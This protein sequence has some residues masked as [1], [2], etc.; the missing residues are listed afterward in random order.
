MKRRS[1]EG[2]E[3]EYPVEW[4][5]PGLGEERT[6]KVSHVGCRLLREATRGSSAWDDSMSGDL[7]KDLEGWW[8]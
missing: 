2:R 1:L 3:G 4:R 6:G 7:D 8:R 5:K